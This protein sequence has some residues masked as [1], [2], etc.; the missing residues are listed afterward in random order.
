MKT[1]KS[2]V[3]YPSLATL[4][5]LYTYDIKTG[6]LINRVGRQRVSVGAVAGTD[7]NDGQK[8]TR[9]TINKVPYLAH[10][11]CWM[12]L[13]NKPIP[14]GHYVGHVSSDTRDNRPDN[15]CLYRSAEPIKVVAPAKVAAP[16][17]APVKKKVESTPAQKVQ[18]VLN[19]STIMAAFE[20]AKT[21]PKAELNLKTRNTTG[22]KGVYFEAAKGKY[23]AEIMF[24]GKKKRLGTHDDLFQAHSALYL[25]KL[26]NN[27][28]D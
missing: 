7:R 12:L 24:K 8:Y 17:P 22:I 10:E 19:T 5:N 1:A 16:A 6:N 21:E 28:V 4:K 13:Y 26:A 3:K 14:E 25:F 20:N 23:R 2:K 9:V 18:K 27:I 11:I 15:F